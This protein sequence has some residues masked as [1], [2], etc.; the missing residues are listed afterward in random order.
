MISP[1]VDQMAAVFRD[2]VNQP[3]HTL[4]T[5]DE[6]IILTVV[7]T[8]RRHLP[9]LSDEQLG[10]ALLTAGWL[11]EFTHQSVSTDLANARY[12]ANVFGVAGERLLHGR[13]AR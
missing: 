9:S 4:N 13:A 5:A 8:M 10:A 1:F 6:S 2:Y 12:T 11:A 3:G 7:E